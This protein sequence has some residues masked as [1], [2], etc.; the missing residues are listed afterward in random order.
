MMRFGGD[1]QRK[2]K[3]HQLEHVKEA[4]APCEEDRKE[5]VVKE[6]DEAKE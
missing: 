1:Q 5:N 2:N 6:T 3:E 4:G